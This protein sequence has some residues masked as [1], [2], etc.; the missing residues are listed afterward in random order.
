MLLGLGHG[1]KPC[2]EP[3]RDKSS[4]LHCGRKPGLCTVVLQDV[5]YVPG[6]EDQNHRADD[7]IQET[8]GMKWF[9]RIAMQ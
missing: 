7:R 5:Q 8:C 6:D 4:T 9:A 1:Q 2:G 3:D